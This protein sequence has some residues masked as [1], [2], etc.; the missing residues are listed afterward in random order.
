MQREAQRRLGPAG[1][2]EL[3]FEMSV[4]ARRISIAGMRDRDPALSEAEARSRLLRR[5]L[6]DSLY[7]AAYDR[8]TA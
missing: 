2:V 8:S 6:G 7:E 4:E 5:L 1:R 3:A